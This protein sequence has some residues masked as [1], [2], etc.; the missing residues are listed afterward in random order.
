MSEISVETGKQ[1]RLYRK[2]RRLTLEDLSRI[3]CKSKSTVSKYEKG[4]I[5]MDIETLCEIA[6]ALHIQ[7]GQLLYTPPEK[8]GSPSAVRR[9]AFFRDTSRLFSYLYDGRAGR[10]LRSALEILPDTGENQCGVMMY[11]NF[12]DWDQVQNCENTYTGYM[13]HFDAVT[14]IHLVNRDLPMEKASIQILASRL[15]SAT[16]WGLWNGLSSRPMMPV[17]AKIL[18]SRT[19]LKE[20]AAL[21]EKLKIS[22]ED[23]RLLKLYNMLSVT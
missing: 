10:L 22:K 23:I 21:T 14:N 17:A 4:E 11:M 12:F 20:D 2:L 19:P 6:E 18:L 1:I 8:S 5:A 3:I 15:D 13:E 7:P 9:P 16:K